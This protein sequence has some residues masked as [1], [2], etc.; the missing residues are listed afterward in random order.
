[1]TNTSLV[2]QSLHNHSRAADSQKLLHFITT[3]WCRIR[4]LQLFL[5]IFYRL[6]DSGEDPVE[7]SEED[8]PEDTPPQPTGQS[9]A[10]TVA[11]PSSP[12]APATLMG[13]LVPNVK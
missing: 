9:Y 8:N 13:M 12:P 3:L 7:P 10:A 1:M 6:F 5:G 2:I 11:L 4:N